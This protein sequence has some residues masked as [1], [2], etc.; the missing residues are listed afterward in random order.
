V[1]FELVCVAFLSIVSQ[2][3]RCVIDIFLS[4]RFE[5]DAQRYARSQ[6]H[7]AWLGRDAD[8]KRKLSHERHDNESIKF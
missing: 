1:L 4:L 6:R 8:V 2:L 5:G 3:W 7:A